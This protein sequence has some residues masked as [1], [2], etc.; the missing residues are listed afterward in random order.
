VTGAA[1]ALPPQPHDPTTSNGHAMPNDRMEIAQRLYDAFAAHDA[2]ALLA[3]ARCRLEF[4]HH[5]GVP[6][7]KERTKLVGGVVGY[8]AEATDYQLG[9][10]E[11]AV[12][13][14]RQAG[15]G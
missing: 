8:C 9:G 1:R 15:C 3:E 6:A 14:A 12:D 7:R 13:D 11:H 4:G 10:I 5:V 2:K